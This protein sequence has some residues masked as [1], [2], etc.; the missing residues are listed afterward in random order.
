MIRE[1]LDHA[2]TM[3]YESVSILKYLLTVLNMMKYTKSM[4]VQ[5]IITSQV[6]Q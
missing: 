5:Q 1:F 4:F 3:T 6:G 2:Q